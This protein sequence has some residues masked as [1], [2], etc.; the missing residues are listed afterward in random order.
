MMSKEQIKQW[1]KEKNMQ[2]VDD[3]QSAL[4]D[5]FAET[6]QEMLEVEM[7]SSL[8]YAKHDMKNKRTTNS[9]IGYSK[10]SSEHGEEDM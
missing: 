4:K 3:V 2:S 9:R 10:K 7:E 1:I 6:I 5:L 8:G